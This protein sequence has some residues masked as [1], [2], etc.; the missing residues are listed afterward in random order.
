MS[1]SNLT[2]YKVKLTSLMLG[3][4]GALFLISCLYSF[5]SLP[6]YEVLFRVGG[7]LTF[8]TLALE[9]MILFQALPTSIKEAGRL[10]PPFRSSL[11]SMMSK[12]AQLCL[13]LAG[14]AWLIT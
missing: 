4:V 11:V 14:V 3:V 2:T 1:N 13:F 12:V 6:T 9:P 8:F 7:G 10:P 5:T